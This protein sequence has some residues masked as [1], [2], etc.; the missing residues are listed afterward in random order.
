KPLLVIGGIAVDIT[1][2]VDPTSKKGKLVASSY[3]G[4][5]RMSVGGVGQNIARAAHLLGAETALM[6]AIGCDAFGMAA[7]KELEELGMDTRFVLRLGSGWHTAVYNA[8]H[9][10][11]G[12]LVAA[13]ADMHINCAFSAEKVR[14][15]FV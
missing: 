9:A 3:P 2:Q 6:T 15:A 11:D 5:V 1:S 8:L 13:V 14:D 7:C 10:F 12:D 4:T